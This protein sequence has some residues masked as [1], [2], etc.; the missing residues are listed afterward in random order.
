M[1]H[2]YTYICINKKANIKNVRAECS[3]KGAGQQD[4]GLEGVPPMFNTIL[5][6][7]L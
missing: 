2:E 7:A 1:S 5:A 6:S 4:L 3:D